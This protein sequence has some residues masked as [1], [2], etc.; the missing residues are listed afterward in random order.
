MRTIA[1]GLL[2]QSALAITR[3]T[4]PVAVAGPPVV[5]DSGQERRSIP[6]AALIGFLAIYALVMAWFFIALVRWTIR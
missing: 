1:E 6:V 2:R 3:S 5:S 4:D